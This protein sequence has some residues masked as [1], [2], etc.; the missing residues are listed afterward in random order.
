M[1]AFVRRFTPG[2]V[3]LFTLF[4][5][6]ANGLALSLTNTPSADTSLIEVAPENSNGGQA[7][8]LSARTQNGPRTRALYRFNL[9][10]LPTNAIIFSAV[11]Q[12]DCTRQ[13]SEIMC[14]TDSAFG[15]H[16]MF[17]P[18]GEGTNAATTQPGQGVPAH[19]GDATW[20]HAFYPT[21]A[22]SA[23]G[24]LADVDFASLES[25]FQ[26]VTTPGA[27]PYRFEST[28]EL[29][30]D[31]QT[32]VRQPA[33]NFG[34]MLISDSEDTICTARRFN[35]REDPNSQPQLE[36]QY[37]VLPRF[38]SVN[39]SGNQFQMRFTPWPGQSYSVE[40]RAALTNSPWLTLT[41][42]GLLTN[43]TSTLVT[44]SLTVTQRFYR[45]SA[46]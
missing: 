12:V 34:W 22:W 7:W 29:V 5:S 46:F 28:P 44:D 11:L 14:L 17:R 25:S 13:S 24:G 4:A 19:P 30:D 37:R 20:N 2:P 9:T 31:V 3:T 15:L 38:D 43:A 18:W 10:A 32:W 36:I 16:R 33:T 41:N 35:S 45:L 23:P 1:R 21:N 42:L 6:L 40:Y 8:V 39:R 26:F 27:S